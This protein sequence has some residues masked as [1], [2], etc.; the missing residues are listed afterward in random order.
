MLE[1]IVD[2]L[3]DL[4]PTSVVTLVGEAY[5]KVQDL[6]YGVNGDVNFRAFGLCI[7]GKKYLDKP[8]FLEI[9]KSFDIETAPI[10]YHG[11]HSKWAGSRR[12]IPD[13]T[14]T[15][16]TLPDV[17]RSE[18]PL[19]KRARAAACLP[20]APASSDAGRM[21]GGKQNRQFLAWRE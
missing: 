1:K 9:C 16:H 21:G 17:H 14:P 7:D 19:Y 12:R 5:G 20:S 18:F 15:G 8:R 11:P 10:L 13:G 4:Q 2:I 6:K 3:P